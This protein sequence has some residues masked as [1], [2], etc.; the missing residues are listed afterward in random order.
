MTIILPDVKSTI[1]KTYK[2]VTIIK[3]TKRIDKKRGN[4]NL[5]STFMSGYI[6]QD[7]KTAIVKGK[8]TDEAIFNTAPAKIQHIKTI[9]KKLA[10]PELKE[11]G[12]SF[13][14]IVCHKS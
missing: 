6:A 7:S 12:V 1:P 4:L 14:K 3:I 10:R 13:T 9:K 2:P 5:S 11:L 8:M